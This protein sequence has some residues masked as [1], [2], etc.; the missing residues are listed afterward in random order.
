MVRY[1]R[2]LKAAIGWV[3]AFRRTRQRRVPTF[4]PTDAPIHR[5]TVLLAPR[6]RGEAGDTRNGR[7]PLPEPSIAMVARE[8][9]A[10]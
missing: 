8:K 2:S 10:R 6:Q 9:M 1:N 4:R 3:Q 5:R 7:P